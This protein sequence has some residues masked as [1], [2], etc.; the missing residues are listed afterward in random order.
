MGGIWSLARELHMPQ[1][2]QKRKKKEKRGKEEEIPAVLQWSRRYQFNPWPCLALLHLWC[3]SCLRLGFEPWPRNHHM[4]HLQSKKKERKGG[5][6]CQRQKRRWGLSKR[7]Q[8]R[9]MRWHWKWSPR[10]RSREEKYKALEVILSFFDCL[11]QKIW[12]NLILQSSYF[13][14]LIMLGSLKI[15]IEIDIPFSLR[16]F[17]TVIVQ[18]Y[19]WRFQKFPIIAIGILNC[20]WSDWSF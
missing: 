4:H 10:Q 12:K 18:L 16:S 14:L 5:R 6:W 2:G 9:D 1:G 11:P 3:K 7:N 15:P 20:L 8:G 13:M 19:V 17:G